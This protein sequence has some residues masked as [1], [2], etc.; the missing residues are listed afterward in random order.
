[1]VR[2]RT[3]ILAGLIVLLGC[4]GGGTGPGNNNNLVLAK[5]SPSGDGQSGP[6]GTTL[7][8][9]YR[10]RLTQGGAPLQGRTVTWGIPG[11]SVSPASTS[12]DADG[13]ASTS[14]TLPPFA[15]TNTVTAVV[16]AASGSPLRFSAVSTGATTSATIQVVND[17]FRPDNLQIKATGT[18]TFEWQSGSINHN[19]TP[20]APNTI[21]ASSNPAPPGLHDAPYSFATVFPTVGTFGY[22][23]SQHGTATTGMRGTITVVP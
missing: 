13:V 2:E 20:V 5:A 3:G 11:G 4:G 8:A 16:T 21:P 17:A 6:T 7:P 22:F 12:T 14:V 23:C 10:A 18:V 1:M 9:P 19:V 15:A